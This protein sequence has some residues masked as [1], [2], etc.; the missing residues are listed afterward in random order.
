MWRNLRAMWKVT[1][2]GRVP[3][4]ELRQLVHRRL[5]H[6]LIS[7]YGSVPYYR[8]VMQQAGYNPATDYGGPQDLRRLPILKR[9]DLQS[10]AVRLAD[11]YR[12]KGQVV[13]PDASSGSTGIPVT[14]YRSASEQSLHIA[15]WMRVLFT[16]GYRI[17]QRV[18]AF[19]HP[20]RINRGVSRVQKLGVL[21]RKGVDYF[22]PTQQ[23]T[24][25]LMDYRPHVLYGNRCHLELVALDI[26]DRGMHCD[27][28][29]LLVVTGEVIH[30][31]TRRLLRE[32]YGIEPVES[33]GS[34]EM[35][36]MA[37]ETPDRDGLH[38]L[39]DQTYFE[40]LD[41]R[42]NPVE[43]GMAGRVIVTDLSQTLMPLIRYEQGDVAVIDVRKGLNGGSVRRLRRIMGRDDDFIFMP[44]GSHRANVE[45][46]DIITS[47]K[48][49]HQFRIIQKTLTDFRVEIVADKA[50]FDPLRVKMQSL[51]ESR[52]PSP[53]R[54]NIRHV[55][56][57]EP[58]ASGK[59]RKLVS[60]ISGLK[61]RR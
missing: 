22:L 60:E 41:Q 58:D 15:K 11:H 29:T 17:Y 2:D 30:P 43:E 48:E 25:L 49:V 35:G 27:F 8:Q 36:V 24:D 52:Y 53:Y 33:Y 51:F 47:F 57:I 37:H 16:N 28:L 6:V 34:V 42:G 61:P 19:I 40:F 46:D 12:R 10:L 55:H 56:R 54:F 7:A 26:K 59:I 5:R 20:E 23:L 38:L 3:A 18:M 14:V 21:R 39:E 31:N 9:Q 45:F 1:R 44:D 4:T 32:S 13:H 50:V